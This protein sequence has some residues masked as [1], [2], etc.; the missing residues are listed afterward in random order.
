MLDVANQPTAFE[1]AVGRAISE[2]PV[3][4]THLNVTVLQSTPNQL[5]RQ[6]V[7]DVTLDGATQW[8]RPIRAVLARLV[9]D[10]AKRIGC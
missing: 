1:S 9:D 10:P 7:L 4:E 5:L 3:V 8:P 6:R 2:R